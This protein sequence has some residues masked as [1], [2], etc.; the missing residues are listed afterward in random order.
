MSYQVE[1]V[2]LPME[3]KTNKRRGFCFVT[4]RDEETVKQVMEKKYHNIGL[5]KV[6]HQYH[7]TLYFYRVLLPREAAGFEGSHSVRIHMRAHTH[8]QQT[9]QRP[10]RVCFACAPKK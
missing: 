8:T 9:C 2:E 7:S 4:F 5:S 10:S 1:A 3:S 6:H